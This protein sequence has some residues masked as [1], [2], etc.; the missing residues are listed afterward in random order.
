MRNILKKLIQVPAWL[1]LALTLSFSAQ[2]ALIDFEVSQEE[3]N[4]G[5]SFSVD[6]LL[7]DPFSG[8]HEFDVLF[9]FGLNFDF[10]DSLLSLTSVSVGD[11]WLEIENSN[12]ILTALTSDIY[13]FGLSAADLTDPGSLALATFEFQTIGAGEAYFS[14]MPGILSGYDDGAHYFDNGTLPLF[15]TRVINIQ[16]VPEPTGIVMLLSGLG[17]LIRRKAK[18]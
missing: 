7:A 12:T 10:D 14:V 13:L 2:S 11:H 15:G 6:L 17:L 16:D 8:Q 18:L 9:G 5:D 4:H 3:I 1:T